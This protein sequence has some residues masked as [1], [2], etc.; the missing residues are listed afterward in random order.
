MIYDEYAD[1]VYL[2]V[3]NGGCEEYVA[4]SEYIDYVQNHGTIFNSF[5]PG[6]AIIYFSWEI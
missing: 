4:Y 3:S 2:R 1:E 5:N 6:N